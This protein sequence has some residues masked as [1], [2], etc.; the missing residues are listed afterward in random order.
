M[1][2]CCAEAAQSG[3]I[4]NMHFKSSMR[5]SRND[6][7]HFHLNLDKER[8]YM[9]SSTR[10]RNYTKRLHGWLATVIRCDQ[11]FDSLWS[12]VPPRQ[13]SEASVYTCLVADYA[14][15]GEHMWARHKMIIM[16]WQRLPRNNGRLLWGGIQS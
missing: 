3:Y 12:S 1:A 11:P 16:I 6:Q 7:I 8:I 10:H 9:Y 14:F 15:C 2:L 13:T 5:A 4:L